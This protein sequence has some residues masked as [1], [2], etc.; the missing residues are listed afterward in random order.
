[1][2]DGVDL[3]LLA[4]RLRETRKTREMT[5]DE[6]S[7]VTGVSIPTLSRVERGDAKGLQSETLLAI[8]NWIGTPDMVELHLRADKNL[9][10]QTATALAS[11]FRKAYEEHTRK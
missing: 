1:M 3:N 5:L 7:R 10:R 9:D 2:P 4:D 8:S 6:V 11:L